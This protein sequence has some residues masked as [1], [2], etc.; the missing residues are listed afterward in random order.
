MYI[1]DILSGNGV[2]A[3][4][5]EAYFD[6]YWANFGKITNAAGKRKKLSSFSEYL[7]YRNLDESLNNPRRTKKKGHA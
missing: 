2:F 1:P 6:D 4:A 7:R 5:G 3:K